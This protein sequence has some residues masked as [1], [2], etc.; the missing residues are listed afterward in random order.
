[1]NSIVLPLVSGEATLNRVGGKGANLAELARSGF[2]VPS[3]FLVTI[4][5]YEHFVRINGISSRLK[6][7]IHAV[8]LEDPNTLDTASTEIRSCFSA[9]QIPAEIQ[10][11]I[12]DAYLDLSGESAV[13]VAVR[14]SA[15]AED[16]PGL[17]FAGQQDT[18]LNVVGIAGVLDAVKECWGSLWTARAIGYRARNA[19]PTEEI[20][21]AVVVQKMI[22]SEVS[23]VL[24][25]ANP[26]SGR[27]DEMV[28]DASYGLGEAIVSG[29]VEPDNYAIDANHWQITHRKLGA[30]ALAIIPR[31]EGGTEQ[32][33]RDVADQQALP[34]A[35]IHDLAQTAHRIA[36]HFGSPQDIEWAWADDQ[37][38]ILQSRPI[39]SL[40]PLFE[41]PLPP[42]DLRAY[43]SLNSLQGV[44][45]PFTPLGAEV[46]RFFI[47]GIDQIIPL[48]PT[49]RAFV[50]EAGGRLFA[51]V[52]Y[53]IGDPQLRHSVL[54][55]LS[56][57][58]PGASQILERQV[59]DG[60]FPA[61][62]VL[63]P[64]RILKIVVSMRSI[65]FVFLRASLRPVSMRAWA[66]DQVGKKRLQLQ[67]QIQAA[68]TL[69]AQ[70][71]AIERVAPRVMTDL[72][73]G[74]LVPAL[75]P[76][77]ISIPIVDRWLAAWLHAG[78]GAS[79]PLLR[80]LPGNVTTEMDL[81]LWAAI[82]T[83]RADLA[84]SEAFRVMS[85]DAL[86]D[87]FQR[88]E[89]PSVAQSALAHFLEQYGMRAVA[90]IDIG[91]P[92]WR[93]SPD[94][95]IQTL[96]SY[97]QI[98]D[99]D[100]APDQLFKK[101]AAESEQQAHE[102]ITQ[103][104][105]TQWGPVR[106]WLLGM[107]IHRIRILC[108][109]RES[110]KFNMIKVFDSFRTALLAS[111][112]NLVEK[113]Q[114]KSAEDIFFVPF[115]TLKR[116]AAGEA[117]ELTPLVLV[118]RAEYERERAR[119]QIP[120]VMFS[121]GEAFYEGVSSQGT[122]DLVGDGVSPGVVEGRVRIV[123]EPHK[124]KLE[125]GEILVCPATDPGWTPLFLSAGGLVMELGGLIT[126]GSVVAREYG[127]PAVVGVHQATTRLQTGQRVRVD[128]SQGRITILDVPEEQIG[129]SNGGSNGT[130]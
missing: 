100:L 74:S 55:L 29:Q 120:R 127:I 103:V 23:G 117:I 111:G 38:Y 68:D 40:Y 94:Q 67:E 101:G 33:S 60:R 12:H 78:R 54:N 15:T 112:R 87:A 25:T 125:P 7:L 115:D 21:L 51:D 77:M 114:L 93:E 70:L 57:V 72:F 82:Q 36:A 56:S 61:K 49:I 24:F 11:A 52:T 4:D 88:G 9:G 97:I 48:K 28:I 34:D 63:T 53:L 35:Q 130:H 1:M 104:H 16:L 17:S 85:S 121:N 2:K 86:V 126:H 22:A 30:K 96:R 27:R 26:L 102:Y 123:L 43:I 3:A 92:R 18:Y 14:S 99:P 80:G 79:L 69:S 64:G 46:M 124:V 71:E 20:A 122:T 89:L 73:L 90:E 41:S 83:I 44:M 32:I 50:S 42:G 58:D 65:L 109:L 76:G 106:A 66:I 13:P 10:Q 39:T 110:P 84:A 62:R 19:I 37:F 95:I 8:D 128:G 59:A 98:D 113:G 119:R 5:A 75:A 47:S 45:D 105:K 118:K 31:R 107:A 108:G 6:M 116:C 129:T 81:R 91:R